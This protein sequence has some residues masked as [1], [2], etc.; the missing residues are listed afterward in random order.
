MKSIIL[1]LNYSKPLLMQVYPI[2][3]ERFTCNTCENFDLCGKCVKN[4]SIQGRFGQ[5]RS[6]NHV[7]EL[8]DSFLFSK[9]LDF[10]NEKNEYDEAKPQ[11]LEEDEEEPQSPD[12]QP[13]DD[14]LEDFAGD[15]PPMQAFVM[16]MRYLR[17]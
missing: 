5:Q 2:Q 9:A 12:W 8:D 4:S 14:G 15:G 13:G 11:L 16:I 7:L 1:P 6:P 10:Q 17:L 3:G